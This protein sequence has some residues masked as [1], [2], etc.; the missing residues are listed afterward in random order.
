VDYG[1]ADFDTVGG[2]YSFRALAF[3]RSNLL[4]CSDPVTLFRDD[5]APETRVVA[6]SDGGQFK[7]VVSSSEY[8]HDIPEKPIFNVGTKEL[9]VTFQ[10]VD[11]SVAWGPSPVYNSGLGSICAQNV[12]VDIL[13]DRYGYFSQTWDVSYLPA[14]EHSWEVSIFDA[15][16]CNATTLII[17]FTLK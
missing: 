2:Y 14:G 16:G 13:A 4:D 5:V 1:K 11:K 10:A 7:H 6:L 12:C 15:V 9:T 8:G 3:L 17:R